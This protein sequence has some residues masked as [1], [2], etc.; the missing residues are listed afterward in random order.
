MRLVYKDELGA[1]ISPDTAFALG[2]WKEPN[3]LPPHL[4]KKLESRL[5]AA[6]KKRVSR[7]GRGLPLYMRDFDYQ[8][9]EDYFNIIW[10]RSVP[11][12]LLEIREIETLNNQA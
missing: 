10:R 3:E 8:K 2:M 6:L 9:V 7:E 11:H 5:R 1:H 4:Q 12:V